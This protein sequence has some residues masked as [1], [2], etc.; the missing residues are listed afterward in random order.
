VRLDVPWC[1]VARVSE[2]EYGQ[3]PAHHSTAHPTKPPI[4]SPRAQ[5][6]QPSASTAFGLRSRFGITLSLLTDDLPK[7]NA[8]LDF[9]VDH[10]HVRVDPQHLQLAVD[11]GHGLLKRAEVDRCDAR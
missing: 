7:P 9:A 6:I 11:L 5:A 2:N 8:Q 4:Q 3:E 10:R 1:R